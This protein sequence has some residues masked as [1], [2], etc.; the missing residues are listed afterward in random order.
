LIF[1]FDCHFF[2]SRLSAYAAIFAAAY[3]RHYFAFARYYL[4]LHLFA[5]A[6]YAFDFLRQRIALI[7]SLYFRQAISSFFRFLFRFHFF[8][9]A[10]SFHFLSFSLLLP[11]FDYFVFDDD[12]FFLLSVSSSLLSDAI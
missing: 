9:H 3:D 4:L 11:R 10:I 5:D 7:I 6:D 1:R 12:Y 2:L 8:C